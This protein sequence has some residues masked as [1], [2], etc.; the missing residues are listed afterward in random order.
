[1]RVCPIATQGKGVDP[2]RRGAAAREAAGMG[3]S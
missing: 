2:I 3:G 1:M